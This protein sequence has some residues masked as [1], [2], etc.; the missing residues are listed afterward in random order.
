MTKSELALFQANLFTA[1]PTSGDAH[2]IE[3]QA[4]MAVE[5]YHRALVGCAKSMSFT[6][7]VLGLSRETIDAFNI[8]FCDRTLSLRFPTTR[9]GRTLMRGGFKRIGFLN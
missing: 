4:P 3:R 6:Q 9:R 7:N 5:F 1:S 8:G 2:I